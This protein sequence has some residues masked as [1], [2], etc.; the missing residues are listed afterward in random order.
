MRSS[1]A[2]PGPS[3][4]EPVHPHSLACVDAEYFAVP[5][6]A[7]DELGATVVGV[8]RQLEQA[9]LDEAVDGDVP[10]RALGPSAARSA[11]R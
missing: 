7:P 2:G 11:E 10:L 6:S 5:T 3:R 4:R 1:L 9:L 8:R